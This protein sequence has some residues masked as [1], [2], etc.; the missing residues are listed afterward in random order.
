MSEIEKDPRRQ[1]ILC[2]KKAEPFP[3][4]Y[5]DSNAVLLGNKEAVLEYYLCEHHAGHVNAASI[6][7]MLRRR[8]H[9]KSWVR[10]V[11]E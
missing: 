8:L 3:F 6:G 7:R 1:C 9:I 2:G 5:G 10:R 11:D 4:P